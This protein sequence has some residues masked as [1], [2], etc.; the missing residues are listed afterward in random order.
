M[1]EGWWKRSRSQVKAVRLQAEA[2][3]ELAAGQPGSLG[4]R[5]SAVI[6][7]ER[8]VCTGE[9]SAGPPGLG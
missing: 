7:G 6:P 8:R 5:T 4:P 3:V 9:E 1:R 2:E